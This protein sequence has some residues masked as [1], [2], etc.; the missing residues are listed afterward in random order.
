MTSRQAT[1]TNSSE[2]V[3]NKL[4]QVVHFVN[5]RNAIAKS[6]A[7]KPTV[8][9]VTFGVVLGVIV[10]AVVVSVAIAVFFVSVGRV[11]SLVNNTSSSSLTDGDYMYICI[12]VYDF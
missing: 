10:S 2:P 5:A 3:N 1:A 7:Q 4:F 8:R 11:T 6:A 12:F 9:S